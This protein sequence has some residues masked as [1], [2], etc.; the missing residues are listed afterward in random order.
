MVNGKRCT[1]GPRTRGQSLGLAQIANV[2]SESGSARQDD[3]AWPAVFDSAQSCGH[4]LAQNSLDENCRADSI[5]AD[6][7][8]AHTYRAAPLSDLSKR[9]GFY[10]DRCLATL[11]HA[12][13]LYHGFFKLGVRLIK[14]V[15]W[16]GTSSRY[17]LVPTQ[18]AGCSANQREERDETS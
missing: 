9:A 5:Q 11:W 8:P 2:L 14:N 1:P 17:R 13:E 16:A 12:V 4:K 3:T 7:S 18:R 15:A 6:P 10:H